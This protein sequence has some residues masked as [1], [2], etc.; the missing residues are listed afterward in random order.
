V[1]SSR[2]LLLSLLVANV[3][4]AAPPKSVTMPL[5]EFL[6]LYEAGKPAESTEVLTPPRDF[7]L[8]SARYSGEVVQSDGLPTSAVFTGR[9]HVEV[10]RP[11]GWVRI[12]VLPA[13]VAL[14]SAKIGGREA[15][16]VPDG[17]WLVL[18]TDRKGTFDLDLDFAVGVE[19]TDGVSTMSFALAPSGTTAAR[20]AVPSEELLDFVVANA[21]LTEVAERDGLRIVDAALPGTGSL[22]VS[23]QRARSEASVEAIPP[24]PPR[25][26]AELE[27]LV[28]LGDGLLAQR[29]VAR[30]TILRGEVDLLRLRIPETATVVSVEG[31]AIRDWRVVDGVLGIELQY[32]EEKSW[33]GIVHL[34]QLLPDGGARVVLPLPEPLDVD[35]T[36]G[37]VG[38]EARGTLEVT[39]EPTED[40][41]LVDVRLLPHAIL[42]VTNSPVLL[43]WKYLKGAV[44]L[45]L[46]ITEHEDIAVL[47]TL[48]DEA[49]ATTMFT[50]DGRRLTSVRFRVRN[51]RKQF[52]RL[53]LP[54]GAELWSA[55]VAGKAVQPARGDD[56]R[57]LLPLIR[58]Q[59]SRGALADFEVGVSYV[60]SGEAPK[61]GRG[62]FRAALPSADVPITYVSWTVWAP[63]EA[64][65]SE[66]SLTGSLRAVDVLSQPFSKADRAAIR[67]T[68]S[69]DG[70]AV[71]TGAAGQIAGGGLGEGA[72]PVEVRI[73]LE[74]KPLHFEKLLVLGEELW[75]AFD[76]RGLD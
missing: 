9:L 59:A 73:P 54:D 69:A 6:T 49:H 64:R 60:E 1:I 25:V 7:T 75:V 11:K 62:R 44:Q 68:Q 23:W 24:E 50:A 63:K 37:Y 34:E 2:L 46:R 41:A 48:L 10:L 15:N 30:W 35:R 47:V 45:P 61:R 51:N 70:A 58:S 36:K 76:Y 3:A 57:V 32:A 13:D 29:T 21:K 40:A 43:G 66:R 26:H 74:G 65:I 53:A 27:T 19:T 39:A 28:S 20:L 31:K 55:S 56:G 4:A 17:R 52:L 8:T 67:T 12:P 22:M 5:D 38:V 42:G 14:R 71:A 72:A 16:V 18:V 33:T